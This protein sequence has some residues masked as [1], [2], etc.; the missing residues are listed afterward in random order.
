MVPGVLGT[1]IIAVI[2]NTVVAQR[3]DFSTRRPKPSPISTE[4]GYVFIDGEYV[5]P[6][7]E[8]TLIDDEIIINGSAFTA[9]SFDLSSYQRPGFGRK[10]FPDTNNGRRRD[11]QPGR[12]DAQARRGD[13]PAG[14]DDAHDAGSES[15]AS[16]FAMRQLF[17]E[18]KPLQDGVILVVR[19]GARPM[20]LW[21]MQSGHDLLEQ[22]LAISANQAREVE[23]PYEV[24]DE[25]D[26][27]T[28]RQL[29]S[30]FQPTPAFI[31]RASHQVNELN[32]DRNRIDGEL[33]SQQWSQFLDYPLTML[34]LIL[35]VIGLGHLMASGHAIF[36]VALNRQETS[37]LSRNVIRLLVI[38]TLMSAIDLVWTVMA[39][40]SGSM[41]EL[42]PIGS[43]LID[44]TSRLIT[45]K[46]IVTGVSIGLLFWLRRLPLTRKAA[47]WCC[48]TMT[49][50]T[51]RW[52][53]FH[54]MLV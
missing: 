5:P 8:I 2:A 52:L 54:S 33:A 1:L 42:N 43:M 32:E 45:F 37:E 31:E 53:S 27:E 13:A 36:S 40:Q 18:L 3:G 24:I 14:R 38:M 47:W 51:V 39:H 25:A 48:L 50:L 49:L 44:D 6:P 28:W 15:M 12:G 22:L 17:H 20:M 4:K 30:I 21:P 10:Q 34:A 23:V 26:R 29:T 46:L 7:Y 35:I 16:Q 9:A 11:T 19:S 41:L